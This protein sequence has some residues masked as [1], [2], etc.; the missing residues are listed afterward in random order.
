M[1]FN[2]KQDYL[3]A[4]KQFDAADLYS[5]STSPLPPATPRRQ[6]NESSPARSDYGTEIKEMMTT[7][8]GMTK[9]LDLYHTKSHIN[10][11][12]H[13][14]S[15]NCIYYVD[16]S[17]FKP[18]KPDVTLFAGS[19]K[20]GQVLGVCRWS[21]MFS[22]GLTVGIGDPSVNEK[23]MIWEEVRSE[24]VMHPEYRWSVTLPSG[25]RYAFA[26]LRIHGADVRSESADAN[27]LSNKNFK[28][29]DCSD[30]NKEALAVFANNRWKSWKKLGKF[31]IKVDGRERGWGDQW[32]VMVLL[33]VLGLVEMSRR[34]GRNRRAQGGNYGG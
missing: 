8:S 28:L 30:P 11:R 20:G 23:G 3:T 7:S 13:D 22:K 24:H 2:E 17:T 29:V 4:G 27:G 5:L 32:E 10:I 18:G 33:S 6:S 1:A 12:I 26:W 25:T 19:E 15:G 31:M 21:T 16:N 34:R 9:S 14:L